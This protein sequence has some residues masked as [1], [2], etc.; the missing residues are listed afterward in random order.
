MA[1]FAGRCGRWLMYALVRRGGWPIPM[2]WLERLRNFASYALG[3]GSANLPLEQTGELMLLAHLATCWAEREEIVIIDVGANDGSYAAAARSAF[4]ARAQIH[5][6]E[7]DPASFEALERRFASDGSVY[8]HQLALSADQG[9]ARLYTNRS[10][11]PLGSLHREVFDL[12]TE[13]ATL[14]YEV[15]VDTLD[16]VSDRVAI[17]CVDLLKLDVEGHE[18]AILQGAQELLARDAIAAVQFEFGSRNLA[19]RSYL[20]DFVTLLKARY[21]LFRVTPRGLTPLHYE[22]SSEM[23]LEETNY[24]AIKRTS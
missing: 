20:R 18:L 17:P 10:G 11:S 22:P 19:S 9:K 14:D 12:I 6:F 15:D 24:S 2:R 23:F 5:C 21:D 7:P 16:R 8:C 1:D 4:G 3:A 13:S